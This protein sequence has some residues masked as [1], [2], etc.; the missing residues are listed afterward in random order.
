MGITTEYNPDLAL[1]SIADFKA[2]K[3]KKEECVPEH[4]KTGNLYD[5]LKRG[6]RV[7]WLEGEI[8]LVETDGHQQLSAPLASIVILEATHFVLQ[9][10]SWTKGQYKAV[11]VFDPTDRKIHFNGFSK[12][13]TDDQN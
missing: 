10:A 6:Q 4:L 9:G 1:R 3:R 11:E 12:L 5:F 8:P 13:P 2:G 7:Y